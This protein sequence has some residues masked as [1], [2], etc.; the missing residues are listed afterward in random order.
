MRVMTSPEPQPVVAAIVTSPL[1]VLAGRRNDGSPPW[2]FIAGEIEPGESPADATVRE[3]KEETGLTV[4]PGRVIAR[5]VHPRTERTLVY[6]AASPVTAAGEVFVGDPAELAEVR[7]LSFP[8][9]M[10]LMPDMHGP[11][12]TYLIE[13]MQPDAEVSLSIARREFD[14]ALAQMVKVLREMPDPVRAFQEATRLHDLITAVRDKTLKPL[15]ARLTTLA[16]KVNGKPAF[17]VLGS[18]VGLTKGRISQ[19]MAEDRENQEA[20]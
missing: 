8:E 14:S 2:T 16:Y 11:V 4:V 13:V 12:V 1:G 6:V 10:D 3:V 7:W 15:R 18:M 19:L 17:D 9:A 5:R 20:D